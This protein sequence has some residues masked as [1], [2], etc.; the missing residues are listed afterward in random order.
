MCEYC[1]KF[2]VP[3]EDLALGDIFILQ[4]AQYS[5]V[6]DGAPYSVPLRYCPACGS[7]LK[8]MSETKPPYPIASNVSVGSVVMTKH[9]FDIGLVGEVRHGRPTRIFARY[10]RCSMPPDKCPEW[11]WSES[12]N[13]YDTGVKMSFQEWKDLSFKTDAAQFCDY[14][15]KRLHMEERL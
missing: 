3:F 12:T 4:S 14:W 10:G 6:G 13:W 2:N 11:G 9:G 1:K 5:Y 7:A 15:R 8:Q